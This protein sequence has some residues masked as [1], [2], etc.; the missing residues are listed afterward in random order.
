L[1]FSLSFNF[2]LPLPWACRRTTAQLY[3][4][5]C[6]FLVERKCNLTIYLISVPPPY[7][8]QRSQEWSELALFLL[9]RYVCEVCVQTSARSQNVL[10]GGFRRPFSFIQ[11]N[12]G[13]KIK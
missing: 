1:F 13:P 3:G 5:T 12:L 8:P 6:H 4:I 2:Q 11:Y 7:G 9:T 10:T